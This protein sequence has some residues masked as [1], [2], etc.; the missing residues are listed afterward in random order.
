VLGSIAASRYTSGVGSAIRSL[1]PA[2]RATARTSLAG[3]LQT[4]RHLPGE[5][6]AA[7]VSR[8][9]SAFVSGIHLAAISGAILAASAALLV[10]RFLPRHI[11]QHAG[12]LTAIEALEDTVELGIAGVPPVSHDDRV[13]ADARRSAAG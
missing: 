11:D 12:E 6:G 5:A 13:V 4:A 9:E 3:A 10:L 7:L 2:D 8:A 1:A